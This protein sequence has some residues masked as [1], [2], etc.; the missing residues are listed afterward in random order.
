M[1]VHDSPKACTH[2]CTMS[3]NFNMNIYVYVC[4]SHKCVHIDHKS[5]SILKIH[6]DVLQC[7]HTYV[8]ETL[9][10]KLYVSPVLLYYSVII[11]HSLIYTL[12]WNLL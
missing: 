2:L 4:H 3:L 12:C 1:F 5:I 10:C 8:Q 11:S 6:F 7:V 9:L